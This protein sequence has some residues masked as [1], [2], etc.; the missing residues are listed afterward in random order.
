LQLLLKLLL[1]LWRL[2]STMILLQALA[3]AEVRLCNVLVLRFLLLLLLAL[4]P[5]PLLH[6]CVPVCLD[7]ACCNISGDC[8]KFRVRQG[9][10]PREQHL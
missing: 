8:C 6:V 9:A 4:Q 7:D 3:Q 1:L 5:L 2:L 10:A